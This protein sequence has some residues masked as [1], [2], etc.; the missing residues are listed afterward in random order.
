MGS[1]SFSKDRWQNTDVEL[2]SG[3][4]G[5]YVHHFSACK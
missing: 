4:T 1:L 3:E 2:N 5:E